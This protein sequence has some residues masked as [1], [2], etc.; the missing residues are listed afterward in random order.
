[1][2]VKKDEVITI[3]SGIFEGY[4]RA[5]P[6]TATQNIDLEAFIFD[7]ISPLGKP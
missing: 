2:I 5:G 4:D 1:M 3:A 7:A 6:F